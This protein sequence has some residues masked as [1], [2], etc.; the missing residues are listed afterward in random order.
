MSIIE[1][2][3]ETG[4]GYDNFE[5]WLAS[6]PACVQALAKEFTIGTHVHEP[7][8]SIAWL[9]GYTESDELIFSRVNP[10]QNWKGAVDARFYVDAQDL[11]DFIAAA[12]DCTDARIH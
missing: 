8:N 2:S 11:R 12:K 4:E 9:I 7:G 5:A 1:E 10:Y 3:I 6:R